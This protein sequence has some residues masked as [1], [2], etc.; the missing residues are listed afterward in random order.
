MAGHAQLNRAGVR[1]PQGGRYPQRTR[2]TQLTPRQDR[3]VLGGL[4]GGCRPQHV[5]RLARDIVQVEGLEVVDHSADL[6]A[7]DLQ[8]HAFQMIEVG[9][10]GQQS[11]LCDD[12]S[13]CDPQVVLA[14][15]P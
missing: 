9:I 4:W 13:C 2:T 8:E 5:F 10:C 15:V 14:H 3:L 11:C 1:G 12:R 6:E 7:F